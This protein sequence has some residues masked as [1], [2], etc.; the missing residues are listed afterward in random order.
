MVSA[1]ARLLCACFSCFFSRFLVLFPCR[2]VVARWPP[3]PFRG[4]WGVPCPLPLS[5][6]CPLS[7]PPVSRPRRCPWSGPPGVASRRGLPPALGFRSVVRCVPSLV[8][9]RLCGFRARSPP[10]GSRP[11]GVCASPGRVVCPSVS[12]RSAPCRLPPVA[13]LRGACPSP[14]RP[15]LLPRFVALSARVLRLPCPALVC[16]ASSVRAGCRL[17]WRPPASWGLSAPGRRCCRCGCRRWPV[18][19]GWLC[20]WCGFVRARCCAWRSGFPCRV[21]RGPCRFRG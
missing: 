4:L 5:A 17:F 7:L 8:V 16:G 12:A 20:G 10:S 21:A 19:C 2:S 9:S 3:R 13:R 15:L 18:C 6:V 14:C 1:R 11:L